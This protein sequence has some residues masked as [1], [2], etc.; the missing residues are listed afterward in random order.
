MSTSDYTGRMVLLNSAPLD[1]V[2]DWAERSVHPVASSTHTWDLDLEETISL[3]Q[4]LPRDMRL[5]WLEGLH[6]RPDVCSTLVIRDLVTPGELHDLLNSWALTLEAYD[7]LL[8]QEWSTY[9]REQVLDSLK[10]VHGLYGFNMLSISP[11][12]IPGEHG[13]HEAVWFSVCRFGPK[14]A[15][16][17]VLGH[18][19]NDIGSAITTLFKARDRAAHSLS[20]E[21]HL[22]D[23]WRAAIE[24]G[25]E[26]KAGGENEQLA[27]LNLGP[28][29]S[30][31]HREL[32]TCDWENYHKVLLEVDR[33]PG[34]FSYFNSNGFQAGNTILIPPIVEEKLMAQLIDDLDHLPEWIVDLALTGNTDDESTTAAREFL[35]SWSRLKPHTQEVF[36]RWRESNTTLSPSAPEAVL[37]FNTSCL[38]DFV[39][40]VNPQ[41]LGRTLYALAARSRFRVDDLASWFGFTVGHA[42]VSGNLQPSHVEKLVGELFDPEDVRQLVNDE[43]GVRRV[44]TLVS[45]LFR[46]AQRD[47]GSWPILD[48]TLSAMHT[49][50][51]FAEGGHRLIDH[52]AEQMVDL[53]L[54]DPCD[55]D[56]FLMNFDLF[57]RSPELGRQ[58]LKHCRSRINGGLPPIQLLA[59][60]NL[61]YHLESFGE[62][63]EEFDTEPWYQA[64]M[65]GMAPGHADLLVLSCPRLLAEKYEQDTNLVDVVLENITDPAAAG[66]LPD[67][68]K[69][70]RRVLDSGNLPLMDFLESDHARKTIAESVRDRF[71]DQRHAWEVAAELLPSWEGSLTEFLDTVDSA[72]VA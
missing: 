43:D 8:Q 54:S 9:L 21:L 70:D 53:F 50:R 13:T 34:E 62:D 17:E 16:Y 26:K 23:V 37:T 36:D 64:M 49:H 19:G 10:Y 29:N 48:A 46:K 31:R 5:P 2:K 18:V 41:Q 22:T 52:V 71:G 59:L 4:G 15:L 14:E 11:D 69:G 61:M 1:V 38:I 30:F 55:E 12:E 47:T 35:S 42:L 7:Y 60:K 67:V 24:L 65:H 33:L 25:V 32:S 40:D 28:H 57:S 20:P 72:V 56:M 3:F 51:W 27:S 39:Q 6:S 68:M 58:V 66:R 63:L 44:M 45:G